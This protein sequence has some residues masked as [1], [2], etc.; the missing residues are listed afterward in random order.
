MTVDGK[1]IS[2]DVNEAKKTTKVVKEALINEKID[3]DL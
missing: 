2:I 1:K 3:E